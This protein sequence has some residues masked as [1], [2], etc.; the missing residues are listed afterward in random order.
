MISAGVHNC[1]LHAMRVGFA[2]LLVTSYM[3]QTNL[4]TYRAVPMRNSML[5]SKETEGGDPPTRLMHW[6]TH[7]L[8]RKVIAFLN[9]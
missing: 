6:L 8:H 5:D 9:N 7:Q 3:R 4:Q 2:V 1:V